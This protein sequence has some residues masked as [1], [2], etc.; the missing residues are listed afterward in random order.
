[1]HMFTIFSRKHALL[2]KT[3]PKTMKRLTVL[4]FALI[5]AVGA[6]QAQSADML[7]QIYDKT[8]ILKEGDTAADFRAERFAGGRVSLSELR[9][10]VVLLT[11]W[12]TW[13]GP[14]LKELS[15]AELP[16]K[17]LDRFGSNADFVFLPVAYT[18]TPTTLRDFFSS[19]RGRDYRYLEPITAMDSDKKI[20]GRYAT[21]SIPRSFVIDREGR[22]VCGSLGASD[23]ELAR[24]AEAIEQT[25]AD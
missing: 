7:R 18:D 21:K 20:H 25:L 23:E 2:S 15:P 14:C 13:C 16:A 17:I 3:K 19:T 1:M 22:I 9:G 12:A 10:K 11:F 5:F 24:V 6:A 8:T 4:I